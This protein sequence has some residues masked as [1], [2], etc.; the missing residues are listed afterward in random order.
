MNA[1]SSTAR[2]SAPTTSA[3][4]A[5]AIRRGRA[6]SEADDAAAPRVAIIN[7]AMAAKYWPGKDPLGHRFRMFDE[8]ITV[9]GIA[10]PTVVTRAAPKQRLPQVYFPSPSG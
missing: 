9:V 4:W 1:S 3:A 6:F 10:E 7:E 2:T 5:R 8:W